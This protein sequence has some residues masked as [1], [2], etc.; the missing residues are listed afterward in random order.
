MSNFGIKPFNCRYSKIIELVL[1]YHYYLYSFY[2][3]QISEL[4]IF[5]RTLNMFNESD[6][7]LEIRGYKVF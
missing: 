1:F 5:K 6:S 3:Q 2:F 4:S 7:S